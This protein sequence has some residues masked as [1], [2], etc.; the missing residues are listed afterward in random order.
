ML[1]FKVLMT[2]NFKCHIRIFARY[3]SNPSRTTIVNDEVQKFKQY[4]VDWWD[5]NGPVKALHTLNKIRVPFTIEGVQNNPLQPSS[6]SKARNDQFPL[7]NYKLIDVGC[8]AGLFSEALAKLG[9]DTTGLDAGEDLI[10]VAKQHASLNPNLSENLHY[11]NTTVEEHVKENSA[12]YDV[13]TCSEVIEHVNNP[14]FFVEQC[15][16]LVKPGGSLIFTTIN[17]NLLSG[18]VVIFL[19]E[20]VFKII[21]KGTHQYDMLV[22]PKELKRMLKSNNC[23]ERKLQG[24][25]LLPSLNWKV[26][27]P[28]A[29]H[30][31][32]HA[33]KSSS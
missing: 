19:M 28:A 18:F 4:A 14:E 10:N 24:F 23:D 1:N 21:P 16:K 26:S 6:G 29:L 3:Y 22:I 15:A 27:S 12:S 31:G 5:P 9:A 25:Y 8:G 20:N 32:I 2:S 7:Q 11:V 30:Y 33:V 17:R 13:L